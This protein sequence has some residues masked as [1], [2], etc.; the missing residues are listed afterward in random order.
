[1][2]FLTLGDARRKAHAILYGEGVPVAAGFSTRRSI[3]FPTSCLT[4]KI[5]PSAE[6]VCSD[7]DS[8]FV[9]DDYVMEKSEAVGHRLPS[10]S[11]VPP[12]YE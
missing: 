6:D 7:I 3:L 10:I 12:F 4:T 1:M 9:M 5:A 2:P 8:G 11:S